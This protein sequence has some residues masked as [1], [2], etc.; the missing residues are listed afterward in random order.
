MSWDNK[1]KYVGVRKV[2]NMI[3]A[4]MVWMVLI[5]CY[6]IGWIIIMVFKGRKGGK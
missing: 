6:F 5:N 3:E 1:S 4:L 2:E